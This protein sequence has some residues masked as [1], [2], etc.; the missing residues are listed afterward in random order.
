MVTNSKQHEN[1]IFLDFDGVCNS[2]DY[3]SYLNHKNTKYGYDEKIIKRLRHICKYGNAR[4]VISS[5]WRRFPLD[6]SYT[7]TYNDEKVTCHNPLPKLCDA[8]GDLIVGTLPKD[9]HM[10]KS[11]ALEI[12]FEYNQ[13]FDGK[14]AI[15]DDDLREGYQYVPAFKKNLWLTDPMFGLTDKIADEILKHFK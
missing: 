13:Q 3:G 2:F 10:S 6:G 14:Y 8:L 7:F 5:N 12:W 11:E 1:L 15:L 9:R 4:I